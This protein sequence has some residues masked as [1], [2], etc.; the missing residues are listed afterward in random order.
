M[1]YPAHKNLIQ[2]RKEITAGQKA[3][4]QVFLL[5]IGFA[6]LWV[7]QVF[8]EM[9]FRPFRIVTNEDREKAYDKKQSDR[10]ARLKLIAMDANDP[11]YQFYDRFID[12]PEKW[13]G[14]PDND[15]Y[16]EWYE[17]WKRGSVLDTTMRW[18][19]KCTEDYGATLCPNFIQYMKIQWALHKEALFWNRMNFL[20]TVSQYYPELTPTFKG[21]EQDLAGYEADAQNNNLEKTLGVEIEKLGLPEEL[22]TYLVDHKVSA[23]RFK[24]TVKTLK[25]LS[26]MGYEPETCI[27]AIENKITEPTKLE[28]IN[29]VVADRCLPARVGLAFLN[30]EITEEELT[31]IENL[32]KSFREDDVD[33]YSEENG[34]SMYDY[35]CDDALK[36]YKTKMRR[37][38]FV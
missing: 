32:I 18:A 16:K 34:I 10:E 27:C 3:M 24:G 13:K 23:N 26:E 31:S 7:F 11:M 15:A 4:N 36:Y 19:P 30:K 29:K 14:S 2:P 17:A 25:K 35:Y 20:E 9:L 1:D 5:L 21:I 6:I 28:I 22:T 8:L 33:I 12:S 37:K 38:A